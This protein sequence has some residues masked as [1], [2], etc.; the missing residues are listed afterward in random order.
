MQ[1]QPLVKRIKEI[2][3]NYDKTPTQVCFFDVD[4]W[5]ITQERQKT[6]PRISEWILILTSNLEFWEVKTKTLFPSEFTLYCLGVS[7]DVR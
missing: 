3:Q 1:L 5:I 4:L 2:G 6:D 7:L